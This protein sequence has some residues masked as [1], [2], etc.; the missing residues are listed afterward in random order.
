MMGVTTAPVGIVAAGAALLI[1]TAG[2]DCTV[3]VDRQSTGIDK[4]EKFLL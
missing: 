2:D 4:L 1:A 3:K